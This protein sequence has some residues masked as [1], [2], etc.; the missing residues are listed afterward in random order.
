MDAWSRRFGGCG[1][2]QNYADQN[3]RRFSTLHLFEP[4]AQYFSVI[5]LS[6]YSD[7]RAG[8]ASLRVLRIIATWWI[9]LLHATTFTDFEIYHSSFLNP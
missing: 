8:A 5:V 9:T 1:Q 6:T 7:K 2:L 3:A 4:D